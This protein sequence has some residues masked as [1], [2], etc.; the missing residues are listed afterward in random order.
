MTM[1][2]VL[3]GT[4][5]LQ[6]TSVEIPEAPDTIA[7]IA[8][9]PAT[10]NYVQNYFDSRDVIRRYGMTFTGGVWELLRTTPDVSPL[11]FCQRYRGELSADGATITG[12]WERSADGVAWEH[13]FELT[14]RRP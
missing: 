5:V 4:F 2:S 6:R 3:D 9:N 14:Y 7:I 10:D 8:S 12:S 13:D 1:E 11:D